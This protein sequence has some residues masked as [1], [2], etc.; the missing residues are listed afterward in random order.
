M[1]CS[2]LAALGWRPQYDLA[3]GLKQTYDWYHREIGKGDLR[4]GAA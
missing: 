4:L 2:R 1:D 3:A